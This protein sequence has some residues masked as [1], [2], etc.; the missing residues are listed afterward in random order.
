MKITKNKK[1][2]VIKI[3]L[4]QDSYDAFGEKISSM[5]PN[6]IGVIAG[7]RCTIS[8]LIDLGYKGDVQEGMEIIVWSDYATKKEIEEFK[9]LCND[10]E[11]DVWEHTICAYCGKVIY[12]CH[13]WG[14]K[15]AMCQDCEAKSLER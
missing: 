9:K 8:H 5:I 10:L 15:G 13:F 12:G 14:D 6:I 11:I 4:Y 3:P 1:D 2:L 7:E